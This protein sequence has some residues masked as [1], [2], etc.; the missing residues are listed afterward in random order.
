M[1]RLR[2]VSGHSHGDPS[3]FEFAPK[4]RETLCVGHGDFLDVENSV[5][6]GL[7]VPVA[8]VGFC[9]PG[10]GTFVITLFVGI[11]LHGNRV[12]CTSVHAPRRPRPFSRRSAEV[13]KIAFS[14]RFHYHLGS[15]RSP[16]PGSRRSAVPT[17]Y[18]HSGRRVR[19]VRSI[20]AASRRLLEISV[21]PDFVGRRARTAQELSRPCPARG[22]HSDGC[23]GLTPSRAGR[24][25]GRC[26]R[27]RS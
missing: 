3:R 11:G 5:P 20:S 4:G 9:G 23:A 16:V 22:G 7:H 2:T 26:S 6:N 24:A 8:G 27:G 17:V 25:A 21:W 12:P 14:L 13:A 15:A 18:R 19:R 10:G 1:G